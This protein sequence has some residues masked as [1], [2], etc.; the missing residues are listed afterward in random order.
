MIDAGSSFSCVSPS[1][2]SALCLA[3]IP[4]QNSIKLENNSS[5]TV[6]RLG[7]INSIVYYNQI[8]LTYEFVVS[9]FSSDI[10]ICLGLDILPKLRICL[11]ELNTVW[12]SSNIP[13]ISNSVDS[14]DY[15][16]NGIPVGT[17]QE[18]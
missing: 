18:R 14:D 1:Y 13:K 16:P 2:C 5:N 17:K 8:R 15:K 4:N 7:I 9:D 12:L 10:P 6:S 11:R 3:S